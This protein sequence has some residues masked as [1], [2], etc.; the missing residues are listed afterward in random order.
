MW[1]GVIV[2][3]ATIAIW[4]RTMT[5]AP[6]ITPLLMDLP[7]LVSRLRFASLGLRRARAIATR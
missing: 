6:S 7:T 2:M 1:T 5:V 3:M 4:V